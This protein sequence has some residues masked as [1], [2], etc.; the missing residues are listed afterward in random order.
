PPTLP[1]LEAAMMIR[2][3]T[4]VVCGM[5]ISMSAQAADQTQLGAG[6]AH[7]E[8]I[9]TASPL[10]QS[11]V[12]FLADA[13]QEIGDSHIRQQTLD[14]F[15]SPHFCVQHPATVPDTVK[16]RTRNT[17]FAQSLV[18]AAD[19]AAIPGGLR[20]GIFPPVIADGNACPLQP[21]SFKAAPGSN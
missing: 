5:L 19:G 1:I 12:D 16:T 4:V 9:G 17:W 11:A 14:S 13:A 15:Q 8:Q 18:N 10:V 21:L 20:A 7:A 3:A 6:N 2:Q